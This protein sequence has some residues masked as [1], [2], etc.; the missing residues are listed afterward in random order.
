MLAG[1]HTHIQVI[2][3]ISFICIMPV[4]LKGFPAGILNYENTTEQSM[5]VF[6]LLYLIGWLGQKR[7]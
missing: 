3:G 4:A 2:E 1:M 5:N 7:P 6:V